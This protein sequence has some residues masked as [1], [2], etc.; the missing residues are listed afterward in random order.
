M[1]HV[2]AFNT[3][4]FYFYFNYVC[5]CAYEY[6]THRSQKVALNLQSWSYRQL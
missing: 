4:Y 5:V 3:L 1:I 2:Y 6:S